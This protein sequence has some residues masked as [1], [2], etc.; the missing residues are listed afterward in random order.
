MNN[1]TY[2]A[3]TN[4]R[5]KNIKFGIRENDRVSHCFIIGKTGVGKTTLMKTKISQDIQN[6]K[7]FAV[8]DPHGDLAESVIAMVPT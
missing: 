2:F 6:G 7:G 5:N 3:K 8:F 4:F 1:I